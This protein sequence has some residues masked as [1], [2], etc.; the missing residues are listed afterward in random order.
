MILYGYT[1]R[2]LLAPWTVMS[3]GHWRLFPIAAAGKGSDGHVTQSHGSSVS[4]RLLLLHD[5]TVSRVSYNL[6]L[7][8][9][10][11]PLCPQ[12]PSWQILTVLVVVVYYE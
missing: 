8:P 4:L 5:P 10:L 3:G 12:L 9:L 7:L 1:A 11:L 6:W 2:P